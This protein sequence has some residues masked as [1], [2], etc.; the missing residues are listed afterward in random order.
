MMQTARALLIRDLKIAARIGGS[1]VMGLIFF[2]MI[3]TLIPFA[4]GPDLNLLSRIGRALEHPHSP[5]QHHVE[6]QTGF[7]L[8]EDRLAPT[9]ETNL[10]GGVK[11]TVAGPFRLRFDYRIFSLLGSP[12]EKKVHRF[13]AGANLKF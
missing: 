13:Y 11:Y 5:A 9:I 4:L 7:A 1:G 6:A 3:V 12:L 10:G 2:L 8:P